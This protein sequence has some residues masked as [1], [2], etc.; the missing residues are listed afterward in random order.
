MNMLSRETSPHANR[1]SAAVPPSRET[2]PRTNQ[3]MKRL[4]EALKRFRKPEPTPC[5]HY[6]DD[7]TGSST[8]HDLEESESGKTRPTTDPSARLI[9]SVT[10]NLP[11]NKPRTPELEGSSYDADDLKNDEA[12]AR[13][14]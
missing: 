9:K 10:F 5:P 8:L 4:V 14:T 13:L 12:D 7:S 2:G 3:S 6:D 1:I 11:E